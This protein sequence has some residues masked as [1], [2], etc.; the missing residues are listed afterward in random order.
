MGSLGIRLGEKSQGFWRW[1]VFRASRLCHF[2]A[3]AS[4]V[5]FLGQHA[6]MGDVEERTP[7]EVDA[8]R[9]KGEKACVNLCPQ[10]SQLCKKENISVLF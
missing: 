5:T 3:W 6:L 8:V 9:I 2:V 10:L 4:H 1:T 7:R